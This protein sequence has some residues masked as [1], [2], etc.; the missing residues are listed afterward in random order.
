[1]IY[2]LLLSV[3][4]NLTLGYYIVFVD[5]VE[6]HRMRAEMKSILDVVRKYQE[7]PKVKKVAPKAAEPTRKGLIWKYWK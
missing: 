2:W 4:L 3:A 5:K 7:I 1:M 6:I